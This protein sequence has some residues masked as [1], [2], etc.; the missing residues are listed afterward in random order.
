MNVP[1]VRFHRRA[2]EVVKEATLGHHRVQENIGCDSPRVS[3]NVEVVAL[4]CQFI[5]YSTKLGDGALVKDAGLA[6]EIHLLQPAS[7]DIQ[8]PT[9]TASKDI[10][11]NLH[12]Y[13]SSNANAASTD[14]RLPVG[15]F[16]HK[17]KIH[18]MPR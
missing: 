12:P 8:P 15:H 1:R 16:Y 11:G 18:Y 5:S 17:K 4:K 6:P 10:N 7:L 3:G 14:P 9:S 2:F 13:L